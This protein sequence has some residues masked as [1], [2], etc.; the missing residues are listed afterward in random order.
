MK[1]TIE[2][3]VYYEI[4]FKLVNNLQIATNDK[5]NYGHVWIIVLSTY[6]YNWDEM[7]ILQQCNNFILL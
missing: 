5:K 4:L 3:V 2:R 6:C 1:E 7:D